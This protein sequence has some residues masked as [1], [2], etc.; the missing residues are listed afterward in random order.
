M[1]T[2]TNDMI[3]FTS[4]RTITFAEYELSAIMLYYQ[5]KEI[6]FHLF[7]FLTIPLSMY[8]STVHDSKGHYTSA[9]FVTYIIVIRM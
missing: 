5:E 8:L 6:S 1:N 3:H 2:I 9:T 7:L 4:G